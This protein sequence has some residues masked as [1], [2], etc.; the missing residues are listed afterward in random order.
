MLVFA[1]ALL[2]SGGALLYWLL[3]KEKERVEAVNTR[4]LLLEELRDTRLLLGLP[5]PDPFERVEA[6]S[7][8]RRALGRYGLPEERDWEKLPQFRALTKEGQ[9]SLRHELAELVILLARARWKVG[10]TEEALQLNSLAFEMVGEPGSRALLFQ[11]A[12]LL[13][14]K[15]DHVEAEKTMASARQRP[16][17][18]AQDY[19][20]LACELSAQREFR[21][22]LGMFEETIR[23][24]PSH[25][26]WAFYGA[27]LAELGQHDRAVSAFTTAIALR[28]SNWRTYLW[29]GQSY[30]ELKEFK[31]G[32]IDF[33]FVLTHRPGF[34]PA[35]VF[36]AMVRLA[37]KNFAGAEADLTAALESDT[38][39]TRT[40]FLRAR[41][42]RQN[43]DAQGAQ[44]DLEEGLRRTPNDELSW[45]ARGL[46]RLPA[47]R[48]GALAD[49]DEALKLVPG[50]RDAAQNKAHV[51]AEYLHRP[52]EAIA[53]LDGVVQRYPDFT[54]AR[55]GR[56]VLHARLG[57]RKLALED[58]T[59][60]LRRDT[61]PLILYQAGCVYALTSRQEADDRLDAFRLLT[62]AVREGFGAEHVE[63]DSD[64]A[65][66]KNDPEYR[67][68]VE[69]A[70][71]R[72]K[73][74]HP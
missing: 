54:E 72:L 22:A 9:D 26:A 67:K 35:L 66:L 39:H 11:R 16:L 61:R 46:A 17:E 43:G 47:D 13:V 23:R 33:D 27:C 44:K 59:E 74:K 5:Y 1:L 56:G 7:L 10:K 48:K 51:L 73:G 4:Q 70:Q 14:Q 2:L 68:L 53:V 49:F 62:R 37:Q 52:A 29:R 40:Y 18:T 36:R 19:Y 21:D 20:L 42:R 12:W 55:I 60:S 41:A 65:P 69:L 32:E 34:A 8:C 63:L 57:Q 50:S 15:G 28:P 31:K 3:G 64:L 24:D 38:E 30:L 45:I 58:A 6:E 25:L 71:E